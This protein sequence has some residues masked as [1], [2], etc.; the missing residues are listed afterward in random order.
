MGAGTSKALVR[1]YEQKIAFY[2]ENL[3]RYNEKK[4][5]VQ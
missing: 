3:K 4:A 2:A 5:E 1:A